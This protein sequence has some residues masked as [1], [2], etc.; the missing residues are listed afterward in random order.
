MSAREMLDAALAARD[1]EDRPGFLEDL[2]EALAEARGAMQIA[3]KHSRVRAQAEA[4]IAQPEEHQPALRE[5]DAAEVRRLLGLLRYSRFSIEDSDE[6]GEYGDDRRVE[7]ESAF[8]LG[9]LKGRATWEYHFSRERER[10]SCDVLG[11]DQLPRVETLPPL[12][13]RTRTRL[14]TTLSDPALIYLLYLV[15]FEAGRSSCAPDWLPGG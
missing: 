4:W 3:A 8:Q 5:A 14:K 6:S 13:K 15:A 11:W 2:G 7:V 10:A 1:A 9:S 12:P